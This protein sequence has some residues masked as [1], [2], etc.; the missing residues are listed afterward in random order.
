MEIIKGVSN[1]YIEPKKEESGRHACPV[2][3]ILEPHAGFVGKYTAV[4][5]I[6]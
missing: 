1:T 4:P 6:C 5:V 2:E 3:E